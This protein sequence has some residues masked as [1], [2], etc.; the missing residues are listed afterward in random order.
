MISIFAHRASYD[1][2]ENSLDG[3][4][5]YA[6]ENIGIE[7]DLRLNDNGIYMSHDKNKNHDLFQDACATLSKYNITVALHLKEKYILTTTLELI[8]S[9]NLDNYFLFSTEN[10]LPSNLKIARYVNQE[11]HIFSETIFWCDETKSSWYDKSIIEKLHQKNIKIIAMSKELIIP[12][13]LN[14]I[15]LEWER[16]SKLNVDGIC[17]NHPTELKDMLKTSL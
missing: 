8:N 15:H 7:L 3:I 6:K 9:N 16:L 12:C 4:K 13:T 11:P 2:F 10:D 1:G 5:F 14:E 17:T